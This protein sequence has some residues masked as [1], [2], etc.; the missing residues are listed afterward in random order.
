MIPYA[1][2]NMDHF[3]FHSMKMSVLHIP[4][5]ECQGCELLLYRPLTFVNTKLYLRTHH[6][7]RYIIQMMFPNV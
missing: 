5:W 4:I 1:Y 2:L 3:I 7:D 6:L